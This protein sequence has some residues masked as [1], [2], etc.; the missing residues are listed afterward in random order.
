[1]EPIR[2]CLI[3]ALLLCAPRASALQGPP[4]GYYDSVD[5]SSAAL[6]RATL[7]AV[8]DDHVRLP[9]TSAGTDTWDVLELA[10][11]DPNDPTRILDVYKNASYA[12]V[13]GGNPLYQR[14]HTWPN[15]YGFPDD[16]ADNYPYT[17]CHQLFLCDGGYNS[18]RSNKPYRTCD[19]ACNELPT[20][21]NDGMGGGVGVYPGNSNW[22]GGS[23]TSGSWETWVGRRGDVARAQFYLDLRYEGGVHGF[24]GFAEPDL[25]L[26]DSEALILASSTGQNESLAYMGMLSVLLAWHAED[27]VDAREAARN[28][29]VYQFQGNRNPFIDN[30]AWVDV[31]WADGGGGPGVTGVPW[32]NE[33]HY[34]N[35]GTDAG[36]FVEVAGPAGLDL[37]GYKLLG[38]N[39]SGGAVYDTLNLSGVL[40]DQGGCRGALAFAFTGLQNGSPDGVALVDPLNQV[41][42]FLSYEGSFQATDGAAAGQVA[43]DIGVEESS[44]TLLGFSLQ[45][46][47]SGASA[48]AFAWSGAQADTPGAPNAGQTFSGGCLGTV[49]A[50]GCGVNPAAS[51]VVVSGL[52][53]IGTTLTLGID[54]PL[55]TQAPSALPFLNLAFTP[56]PAFPCGLSLPG[57]GMTGPGAAGELLIGVLPPNP[58]ATLAGPPWSGPGNPA[59]VP[60]AIPDDANLVGVE[61]YAQGL[62]F[63]LFG[64]TGV[65]FGLTEAVAIALG[66]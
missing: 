62:L 8:I 51:L 39:G 58:I 55:G 33:L 66:P 31:L 65:A 37:S 14:E 61:V 42:E 54:N 15:S 64:G 11:E 60:V 27:P 10:D 22:E 45:R 63:D 4:A 1:M 3:P 56:D 52:A 17:D 13:G 34:D 26:T 49:T 50:Y 53:Q 40:A 48:S 35:A 44:S 43:V 28:D 36:E 2:A 25:V 21:V 29:A 24:T 23:F 59:P 9:Y 6:L 16:G 30:P 5:D 18:A 41:L 7:H 12:K 57:F 46:T 32:I 19:S 47:G 20:D 38:Y